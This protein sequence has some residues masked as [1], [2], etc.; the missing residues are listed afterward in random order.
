MICTPKVRHFWR[1][2]FCKY[3][4]MITLVNIANEGLNEGEKLSV[5][6]VANLK[7]TGQYELEKTIFTTIGSFNYSFDTI[8]KDDTNDVGE[9]LVKLRQS[10]IFNGKYTSFVNDGIKANINNA[11]YGV[12]TSSEDV[13]AF[14][15]ETW[16]VE[17]NKLIDIRNTLDAV[18]KMTEETISATTIAAFLD[19]LDNS[20]LVDSKS[21]VNAANKIAKDLNEHAPEIKDKGTSWKDTFETLLNSLNPGD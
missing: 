20:K 18:S 12:S 19:A 13:N 10:V 5:P 14:T 7:E 21:S 9:M 2:I 17:L 8:T 16:E 11:D 4:F 3:N 6:T 1:C 15:A